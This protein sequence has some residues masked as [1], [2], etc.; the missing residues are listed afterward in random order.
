[1]IS[2]IYLKT[3]ESCNLNCKH[4]F[5]GGNTPPRNFFNAHKTID[6]IERMAQ[7]NQ[8]S[9]YLHFELHGGEP[10][11]APL[12]SIRLVTD[13]IRKQLPKAKIG[14]TTN[15]VY[16]L[17]DDLVDF[18]FKEIDYVGTSWD[19]GIRFSN[20][21]Q[22]DLWMKNVSKLQSLDVAMSLNVSI[23]KPLIAM[24]CA[25]LIKRIDEFSIPVVQFERITNDGNAANNLDI[26]PTNAEVD[27]WYLKMHLA[28]QRL[29]ARDW[30]T[31]K[32]LEEIYAKF[33]KNDSRCGTYCRDCEQTIMTINA[34]GSIAGCPNTAQLS[35]YGHIDMT[36]DTLLKQ[37]KRID[38]IVK[39]KDRKNEC[40]SCDVF[41]HCGSGCHQ[42]L[43][44]DACPSPKSLMLH[45]ADQYKF[46]TNKTFKSIPISIVNKD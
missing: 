9:E 19:P 44:D 10:M 12:S 36:I 31:N 13:K 30:F 37:P 28:T 17:S 6:W 27:D 40:Y 32:S 1:M 43:W 4:C 26:F 3:T 34:D 45:L 35:A 42:L 2:I 23:S 15:L 11:L 22:H 21:K 24:E 5:T 16:N 14:V 33:E 41:K 29:G 8:F 18:L 20:H 7:S 39:E 46:S 25:Q 38:K